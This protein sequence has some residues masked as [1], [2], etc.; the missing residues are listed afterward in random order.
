M[1][2]KSPWAVARVGA[3]KAGCSWTIHVL[4]LASLL[5]IAWAFVRPPACTQCPCIATTGSTCSSNSTG[6]PFVPFYPS[7]VVQMMNITGNTSRIAN[8][9]IFPT[10]LYCPEGVGFGS[11]GG[12]AYC[13]SADFALAVET[14]SGNLLRID[15]P[16][17]NASAYISHVAGCGATGNQTDGNG[18]TACFGAPV[19]VVLS[20]DCTLAFVSDAAPSGL[21]R[22]VSIP[23]GEVTTI[24]GGGSDAAG[25]TCSAVQF[26]R[27]TGLYLKAEAGSL[28]VLA[29]HALYRVDLATSAVA[30]LAG[31][32]TAGS[33]DATGAS[34]GL[35]LAA[36]VYG[37]DA[38]AA[39]AFLYFPE[40]P[41]AGSSRIRAVEVATGAVRTVAAAPAEWAASTAARAV[42]LDAAAGGAPARFVGA[43]AG[44]VDG[45]GGAALPAEPRGLVFSDAQGAFLVGGL[46]G[47][48]PERG[49]L[50]Y[51]V[52]PRAANL[53]RAT[54]QVTYRGRLSL[55]VVY[56]LTGASAGALSAMSLLLES[57]NKTLVPVNSAVVAGW[58]EAYRT[59]VLS[60]P[61]VLVPQNVTTNSTTGNVTT[62][63][64]MVPLTGSSLVNVS[65]TDGCATYASDAFTVRVKDMVFGGVEVEAPH[66]AGQELL[67]PIDATCTVNRT[68]DSSVWIECLD[69]CTFDWPSS[70][71]NN[72]GVGQRYDVRAW[73]SNQM[74]YFPLCDAKEGA[75]NLP[76]FTAP[77]R[78][79]GCSFY[80]PPNVKNCDMSVHTI[81]LTPNNGYS[82]TSAAGCVQVTPEECTI[83]MSCALPCCNA[84]TC[85]KNYCFAATTCMGKGTCNGD[86]SCTCDPYYYGSDCSRFCNATDTCQ[87]MGSCEPVTGACICREGFTG[88]SCETEPPPVSIS[89]TVINAVLGTPMAGAS[90]TVR[91]PLPSTDYILAT[92][93][94]TQA[95][96]AYAI[97]GWR[98]RP[99]RYAL[100]ATA[101]GFVFN[102]AAFFDV[103][104]P[105]SQFYA[106]TATPALVVN[107]YLTPEIG[108][109]QLRVV[110]SWTTFPPH[111]LD[112]H[113]YL[114]FLT[115]GSSATY[116]ECF[117]AL[118]S[119]KP[120]DAPYNASVTATLD[121]DNTD[122]SSSARPETMTISGRYPGIYE[123]WVH[124]Y[125]YCDSY[126]ECA[127]PYTIENGNQM[128]ASGVRV[129]VYTAAGLVHVFS[130]EASA[131]VSSFWWHVFDINGTTFDIIP[132]DLPMPRPL[133]QLPPFTCQAGYD[134]WASVAGGGDG[135]P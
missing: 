50:L 81:A 130:R 125:T 59:I 91:G 73:E 36:D 118:K 88:P 14:T 107:V 84:T 65:V 129:D 16:F 98:Y 89:G 58:S 4:L 133:S 110:M 90:I 46:L 66:R 85:Q 100:Y 132:L 39:G 20:A 62:T 108:P 47:T 63:T 30:L 82:W 121:V 18:T 53:S 33:A 106:Q 11:L 94:P 101:P 38:D 41:A 15:G 117:W 19:G 102:D 17:N 120:V 64:V 32:A 92:G 61:K 134:Q 116:R 109:N 77:G 24:C 27:P 21:I 115:R 60:P 25:A 23:S 105:E 127:A 128:G 35:N 10:S 57:S 6:G 78:F 103:P 70:Y 122:R 54:D 28:Y 9:T 71:P 72:V 52:G 1:R 13:P 43:G 69:T 49:A 55:T 12:V 8:T 104:W 3:V 51:T 34:A 87:N 7:R 83:W 42:S 26:T 76:P 5:H 56:K 123:Y 44:S 112:A 37:M 2:S 80:T 48:G 135:C 111:D 86:G 22:A 29:R 126:F 95:N 40:T 113:L 93:F 74:M 114:P 99:G 97:G 45:S 31:G 96:G 79:L 131:N 75:S 68:A 124:Q 119:V 67:S